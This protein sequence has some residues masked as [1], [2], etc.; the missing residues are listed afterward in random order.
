MKFDRFITMEE[1]ESGH[2]FYYGVF[3]PQPRITNDIKEKTK[4]VFGVVSII[5]KIYHDR[6]RPYF[7]FNINMYD[8]ET[9]LYVGSYML[10]RHII[11]EKINKSYFGARFET[12]DEHAKFQLL[13]RGNNVRIREKRSNR[14]T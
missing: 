12:E 3:L 14:N 2:P 7:L 1:I 11:L 9:M 4:I 6:T 10:Q 13:K 8:V 5:H